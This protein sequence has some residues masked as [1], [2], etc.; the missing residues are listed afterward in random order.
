MVK[1]NQTIL[2]WFE[3]FGKKLTKLVEG[4]AERLHGDETLLKTYRKGLFF[5]F[6]VMRCKGSQPIGWHVSVD[7]NLHETKLF[8]WEVRRRFPTTYQPKFIRTDKM[9]AYR[10]AIS[11][12]FAHNV[13]HEKVISFKHGNNVIE[14]FWRCKNKFPR[15]RTIHNAKKFIDHWMWENFGDDCSFSYFPSYAKWR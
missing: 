14:N 1:S 10:E 11:S 6:W 5:Y 3:K 9:P 15:F 12:V 7:R 4:L 13:K 8:M 2:N